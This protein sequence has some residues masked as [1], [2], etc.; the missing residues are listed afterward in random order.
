MDIL[1]RITVPFR[2]ISL[3]E[4][5]FESY[6][7]MRNGTAKERHRKIKWIYGIIHI[8]RTTMYS[9]YFFLGVDD[10]DKLLTLCDWIHL[11]GMPHQFNICAVFFN[12]LWV[13]SFFRLRYSQ[14]D[15]P[16]EK[17][18]GVM[19][20]QNEKYFLYKYYRG[21]MSVYSY[22]RIYYKLI[23][24]TIS[25]PIVLMGDFFTIL[26]QL[27]I[28]YNVFKYDWGI[29]WL[30]LIE[31]N[32]FF[33]D[34]IIFIVI[35]SLTLMY[36]WSL[37]ILEIFRV[38]FLQLRQYLI[39]NK[40]SQKQTYCIKRFTKMYT[41]QV[42]NLLIFNRSGGVLVFALFSVNCPINC[43][44][45]CHL[46]LYPPILP[47]AMFSWTISV[48]QLLV[49]FVVHGAI[50]KTNTEI[51]LAAKQFL[52]INQYIRSPNLRFKIHNSL[53][54]ERYYVKRKYGLTYYKFGLVTKLTFVKY[55]LLYCQLLMFVI[56]D[57][58]KNRSKREA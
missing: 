41:E 48:V 17:L 34:V 54:L 51:G 7:E 50:A 35:Y 42:I 19:I 9:L 44:L 5:Y 40:F 53:F 20:L 56:K 45:V 52:L 15:K 13:Y 33:L 18:Y 21:R 14:I 8:W 25:S 28:I 10:F 37:L 22:F 43:Y 3:L 27:V 36:A 31:F 12:F 32:Q 58:V 46:L 38:Q 55:M 4:E 30:L 23:I 29:H 49:I 24:A 57:I 6:Y 47:T 11:G 2:G 16:N 26:T 39:R 1:I